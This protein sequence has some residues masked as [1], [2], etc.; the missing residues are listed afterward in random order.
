MDHNRKTKKRTKCFNATSL[1]RMKEH[2]LLDRQDQLIQH[3]GFITLE[4]AVVS[5]DPGQGD[6][7]RHEEMRAVALERRRRQV[8]VMQIGFKHSFKQS[9][10]K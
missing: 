2:Y 1:D 5:C 6:S 3:F 4:E 10:K 9:R 8:K 7:T